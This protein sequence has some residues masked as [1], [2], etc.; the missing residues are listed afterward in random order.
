[1]HLIPEENRLVFLEILTVGSFFLFGSSS[2]LLYHT[3]LGVLSLL[4]GSSL[5]LL[6][7]N[8]PQIS[9]QPLLYFI[10]TT[11]LVYGAIDFIRVLLFW[12]NPFWPRNTVD[13]I[14]Q[15]W[16]IARFTE[17][18]GFLAGFFFWF[19]KIRFQ[20]LGPVYLGVTVFLLFSSLWWNIFP[21]TYRSG[22]GLTPFTIVSEYIISA[23]F[24]ISLSILL[25][26]NE[27]MNFHIIRNLLIS[28]VL[29]IGSEMIFTL[30]RLG[31]GFMIEWRGAIKF[32]SLLFLYQAVIHA[33]QVDPGWILF[34]KFPTDD[35]NEPP[36]FREGIDEL[37]LNYPNLII[38]PTFLAHHIRSLV[39]N[40][41][42]LLFR[43]R[44][45]EPM[46]FEYINPA[47]KS[48]TGYSPDEFY[49]DSTLLFQMV[50]PQDRP[51]MDIFLKNPAS[52]DKPFILRMIRK[53]GSIIWMEHQY[54]PVY[55]HRQNLIAI[56]GIA[57]DIT[58]R[59]KAEEQI[60][61][62]SFHDPLTRLYNRA[63]FEEEITRLDVPNCYPMSMILGDVNGIHLINEAFGHQEGDRI[64]R[65]TAEIL[66]KFCRPQDIL[67]RWGEDEFIL[68]LP[69]TDGDF[70]RSLV[71]QIQ[72]DLQNVEAN[73]LQLSISLG[74]AIKESQQ[75]TMAEII[76]TAEGWMYWNKLTK[77]TELNQDLVTSIE[78]S[79]RKITRETEK[80]S[81]RLQ[82]IAQKIGFEL[83]LSQP[84]LHH[85]DLLARLHDLGKIATPKEILNKS[86]LLSPKEWDL[87]K[88]HPE[89]GY[90]IA[91]N[92][93]DLTPIAE[94]ILSHHERWD[95]TGYPR[96]L[97]GENIPLLS[98]II[99]I[100]DTF[101]VLTDGRTYK[102]PLNQKGALNE[103]KK[104]AGHQFDPYLVEVFMKVMGQ[105]EK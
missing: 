84:E 91:L 42:D 43:F 78:Q 36:S 12:Y 13:L 85:L 60:K 65:D 98:R 14:I 49:A 55:D 23:L 19:K 1:M 37:D 57:R 64:I 75:Q 28:L 18:A 89:I 51:L 72:K 32:I 48:I 73:P 87:V 31:Y 46:A 70:T 90:R 104:G 58:E 35:W 105:R 11:I 26:C 15:L 34:W 92:S 17:S 22:T 80:H 83:G 79:L 59:K 40:A 96:G 103:I 68:F 100:A 93:P 3:T 20:T 5:L 97:K 25:T 54:V 24:Y 61:Y 39:D 33:G 29:S 41:Q 101:D 69:Q 16:L 7:L 44:V 99:A 102:K 4:I 30:L 81:D 76:N 77:S 50:H 2:T 74:Y 45:I 27:K 56:E 53:D 88:R 94:A 63:Y 6:G 86:G 71:N 38:N 21:Q 47:S 95:G 52:L 9:A 82:K 66:K 62:F 8:R 67:A 10:I